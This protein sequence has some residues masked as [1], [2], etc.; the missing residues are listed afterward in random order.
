VPA[1]EDHLLLDLDRSA[2]D[3][4]RV[5]VERGLRTAIR[6]GR[7][8]PDT[9]LPSTRS[10]SKRLQVSRGIVVEAYAQLVAEGYLQ[11]R[12]GSGTRVGPGTPA[13]APTG[14]TLPRARPPRY[15]FSLGVPDLAAF[16]RGAWM[17]ALR[18]VL[19][20]A[21]DA[22]LGHPDPR[23]A[24]ELRHALA[25][26]LGRVRGVLVAPE[27][28][29]VCTGFA[30]GLG[31][32]ARA[33]RFEGVRRIAMEDPGFVLHRWILDGAGLE[34]VPVPVD[35][36][37]LRVDALGATGAEAVLVAP[38]RQ[39]ITGVVLAPERRTELV[40]W[41]HTTGGLIV[42]DDYDAEYRYDRDP[43]G[44]LQGLAPAHV[45][46]GGSVSK[47]LAPALRL[48][49]LVLPERLGDRTAFEKLLADAGSPTLEQLAL[50][51]LIERGEHDRHLRRMRLVYRSR[52][53]AFVS[54]VAA[55]LPGA[56]VGG[57]A[58]GLHAIVELPA[59]TDEGALVAAARER[60]V[61]I[62]PVFPHRA[63]ADAAVTPSVLAGYASL[64]EPAIVEG[65]R[66]IGAAL[67]AIGD[68]GRSA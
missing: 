14:A 37:G 49:W 20:D 42:E 47:T 33:L 38:A 46:Y 63:R 30:Q 3:G 13:P 12:Q 28:V 6:D 19:R 29:L 35:D 11:A 17:A 45:V 52:R 55:H 51:D 48:G 54:A 24:G 10:L 22:R 61:A 41:A 65:V 34:V 9:R 58:A 67:G 4:V 27:R 21:P 26:Y 2:G 1:V 43:V 60:D 64:P 68:A 50:A 56:R 15:D 59:G 5:Q 16:P 36:R 66:R 62:E 8:R 18:R 44:A 25:A 7:L 32:V 31:L 53:D 39:A 23:G 57:V 40:A